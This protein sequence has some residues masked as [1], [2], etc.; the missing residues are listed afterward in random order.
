MTEEEIGIWSFS[1]DP[2][3]DEPL[4]GPKSKRNGTPRAKA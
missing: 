1:N 4:R 2:A 3:L